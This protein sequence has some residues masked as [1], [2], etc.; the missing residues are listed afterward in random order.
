MGGTRRQRQRGGAR[1]T[2]VPTTPRRCRTTLTATRRSSPA[3]PAGRWAEPEDIAGAIVFLCSSAAD[4]VHGVDPARRRGL[5]RAMSASGDRER[6]DGRST[7]LGR[8][9]VLPVVVLD[10]SR[11]S[12][13][14]SVRRCS[15]GGI[16]VHRDHVPHRRGG[17]RARPGVRGGGHA[18]RRRDGADGRAGARRCRGR[19]PR[20]PS[21]REPTTTSSRACAELGLPFFP[22]IAT[23]SE[24]GHALRLGCSTVKVFPASTLGGPAF[25]RAV[26]AT[27]PQARFIP[28]GGDRRR[29]ARLLSRRC[30]RLSPAVA[31]GSASS[32]APGAT[33]S[34]RIE[35]RARSCGRGGP[36]DQAA[37]AP[38]AAGRV[39]VRAGRARRGDA[40]PR[41]RRRVGSPRRASFR[42]WEGGGE[43]N[44]A[45]GLRRCFGLR[46]GVVT[47]LADNPVGRLI[48][49]LILQGGV[50]QAELVWRAVRRDRPRG[51]QRS[52]LHRARLR[53]ARSR[54]LLRSRQLRR[55]AA[56]AGRRRL[57][58]DLRRRRRAVVPHRRRLLRALGDA[59]EVALEA[60]AAARRHGTV[61][62]YD[63]NYRP[64]L[65]RSRGGADAAAAVNREIVATRG[66]PVRERGG[67]LRRPRLSPGGRTRTCSSSMSG[68]T[69]GCSGACSTSS[70]RR[71][72]RRLDAARGPHGDASTTGAPSAGRRDGFHRRPVVRGPRDLRPRRRRR[73]VRLRADL[74]LARGL[75]VETALAYGV[76]HGALAMTTPGDTSMATRAE[77]ERLVAGRRAARRPM[78]RAC[79]H[80]S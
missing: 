79:F 40:S 37:C 29:F 45:R 76:A 62:S 30:R 36:D 28:T 16:S 73:L 44:V 48:E 15:P 67:L 12:S 4:Y 47:A 41:P 2:F 55:V 21:R 71:R 53:R 78:S 5:A 17:R 24:L 11:R 46:T 61:V 39:P 22:G 68:A 51:S 70:P 19:A 38:A 60:V 50:E 33:A 31:A 75:D 69:S 3:F 18:G 72:A 10:E 34:T 56:A 26:S 52:Q 77:V 35:R 23:P 27:F 32:V 63:L 13:P 25:L 54:R 57:G 8:A 1:A 20:S 6:G 7:T 58:A 43:Y 66:R 42:V 14:S 9:R 74:R 59:P 49:D 80:R 65:W 64:S